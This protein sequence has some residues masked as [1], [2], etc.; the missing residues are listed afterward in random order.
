MP[1]NEVDDQWRFSEHDAEE[2]SS[3]IGDCE[4][5]EL[6]V[7]LRE[8]REQR[9]ERLYNNHPAG[10]RFGPEILMKRVIVKCQL[11]GH[12]HVEAKF[13]AESWIQHGMMIRKCPL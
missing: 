12:V 11:H 13:T 1:P 2:K 7:E 4:A 9:I 3:S 8:L 10:A 5:L 6:Q